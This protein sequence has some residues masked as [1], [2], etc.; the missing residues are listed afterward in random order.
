MVAEA[1]AV[2][3]PPNP[4][5]G[6]KEDSRGKLASLESGAEL[7]RDIA[8][9][10]GVDR[11]GVRERARDA[12]AELAGSASDP[13][14]TDYLLARPAS[15]SAPDMARRLERRPARGVEGPGAGREVRE[16]IAPRK[17]SLMP[18]ARRSGEPA[19]P[20]HRPARVR[21]RDDTRSPGSCARMVLALAATGAYSARGGG[22]AA[23]ESS[24]MTTTPRR[25]ESESPA[26]RTSSSR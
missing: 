7:R 10:L 20:P 15:S 21:G 4:T 23:T 3:A 24:A 19:R 9:V 17:V 2:A 14:L 13:E 11:E 22:R 26:L 1:A 5:H 25:R 12:L 18:A 6:E 8:E 16:E